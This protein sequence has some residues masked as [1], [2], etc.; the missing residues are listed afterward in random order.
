[1][2]TRDDDFLSRWSRRKAEKGQGL[3]KK[4]PV[5][6]ERPV[7]EPVPQT[8]HNA[9]ETGTDEPAQATAATDA[10]VSFAEQLRAEENE[11]TIAVNQTP[12]ARSDDDDES[13][14]GH[15]EFDDVDFDK[16][17]F[18]SDYTRF[19]EK[20]VPEAIRRRALRALWSSNP[21]LANIDGLNDYDE[22][23]TDAA[24]AIKIIGSN[25][26]PGKGY[27]TDEERLASYHDGEDAK[28]DTDAGTP[29]EEVADIDDLDVEDMDDL[30]DA[31]D[32]GAEQDIA[33]E[34]QADTPDGH[35][36]S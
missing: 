19:M 36:K 2:A 15:P 17:N 25:Y 5:P 3:S 18:G 11:T 28:S 35:E 1:M 20:G 21:V 16:L 33:D 27:L 12:P 31:E 6:A 4:K 22:D 32:L 8:A 10:G 13:A 30:E 23:F 24:L 29:E 9:A 14:A 7:E 26:K 34:D